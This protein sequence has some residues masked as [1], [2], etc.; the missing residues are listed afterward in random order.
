MTTKF[1]GIPIT[2]GDQVFVVPPLSFRSL[3]ALQAK[4]ESYQGGA[5]LDS[6]NTV[7]EVLEHAIK[8]NYPDF[9]ASIL[10]DVLDV[11][12]MEEVMDACMDVS[13]LKRKALEK[14][15]AAGNPSTGP[16][17]TPS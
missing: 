3:Q 10:P 6:T 11:G 16:S 17:S 2:L 5:G 1:K 7:M 14:E 4:I 13:G 9:D 8:R 15:E 12:N